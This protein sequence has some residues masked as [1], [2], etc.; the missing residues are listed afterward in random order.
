M[1]GGARLVLGVMVFAVLAIAGCSSSPAD[2]QEPSAEYQSLGDFQDQRADRTRQ[3]VACLDEAG[4]PGAVI[5]EDGS[6]SIELTAEQ[7]AGY[8]QAA[9]QCLLE[10][11][12]ACGEPPSAETLTRLYHLQLEAARCLSE[13]GFPTSDPPTLQSYLEASA[14]S[15]WSPH[16]EAAPSLASSGHMNELMEVCPDPETFITYW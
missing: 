5:Q 6:T 13:E 16:R 9:S 11:C 14:E 12:P 8:N 15:R 2:Q 7:T 3:I 4:F 1:K 10:A